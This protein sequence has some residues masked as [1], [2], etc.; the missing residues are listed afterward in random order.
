MTC[1]Q[2][3]LVQPGAC[4]SISSTQIFYRSRVGGRAPGFQESTSDAFLPYY[5]NQDYI[6]DDP[7]IDGISVT[8]GFSP[9]KHIWSFAGAAT[10]TGNTP[11]HCSCTTS[12]GI[13][14]LFIGND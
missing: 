12:S 7:Y 14:P 3:P 1:V 9:R 6:I 13:V 8:Y 11:Y 2:P 10:D 4:Q 5:D